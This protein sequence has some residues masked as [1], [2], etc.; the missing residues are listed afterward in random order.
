[1]QTEQ[2]TPEES[3]DIPE[4]VRY[5]RHAESSIDGCDPHN[6]GNLAHWFYELLDAEEPMY[7]PACGSCQF[8]GHDKTCPDP[9]GFTDKGPEDDPECDHGNA[10]SMSLSTCMM[11][12]ECAARNKKC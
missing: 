2:P 12:P 3:G 5:T 4:N 9:K 6:C 8:D 7:C 10:T 1:M 11:T